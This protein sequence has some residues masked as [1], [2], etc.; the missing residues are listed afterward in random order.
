MF[1]Y[2]PFSPEAM[3]AGIGVIKEIGSLTVFP[4]GNVYFTNDRIV[5]DKFNPPH[6]EEE[7]AAKPIE[8]KLDNNPESTAPSSINFSTTSSPIIS[9]TGSWS[10]GS[11]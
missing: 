8:A 2:D 4:E 1:Q 5:E 7:S 10:S 6:E 9:S 3:A 11:S